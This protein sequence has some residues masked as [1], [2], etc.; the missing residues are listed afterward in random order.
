M[1]K[2]PHVITMPGKLRAVIDLLEQ[3]VK[4]VKK[5]CLIDPI[6]GSTGVSD[7]ANALEYCGDRLHFMA[8]VLRGVHN[9]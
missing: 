2:S 1:A 8:E 5:H 3:E 7:T 9:E 4:Q 6:T